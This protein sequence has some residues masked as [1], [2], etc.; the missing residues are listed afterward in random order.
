[1]WEGDEQYITVASKL[2]V[3]EF[4]RQERERES[5]ICVIRGSLCVCLCVRVV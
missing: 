3:E 2:C 4:I 1:M 5:I